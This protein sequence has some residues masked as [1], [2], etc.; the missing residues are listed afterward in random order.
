MKRRLLLATL[1]CAA[2]LNAADPPAKRGGGLFGFGAPK[3]E[4]ISAGLFPERGY[5]AETSNTIV[6]SSANAPTSGSG[7][8]EIFRSGQPQPVDAVS[9]VIQNGRKVERPIEAAAPVAATAA[10][11]AQAVAP[12]ASSGV[13]LASDEGRKR[14][15]L[16]AF[17]RRGD[18]ADENEVV[19]PVPTEGGFA[20][21]RATP[22]AAPA[23]SA[24]PAPAPAPVVAAPALA[25]P[26]I[27]AA[28]ATP[29]V[30]V[31]ETAE[32]PDFAGVEKEKGDKFGWI[33]FMGR[34]KQDGAP[35]MEAAAPAVVATAEPLVAAP[36][37][38]GAAPAPAKPAVAAAKPAAAST[39][40]TTAT[41]ATAATTAPT[42]TF[43]V[44]RD[45]SKK[46]EKKEVKP[47]S[48]GGGLLSPIANI[49]VPRKEIDL[50]SAETII[51]DGEIVAGSETNFNT[52]PEPSSTV[53]RQA[54]QVV[55]GVK[56]YTSWG[57]V[58]A[59]SS[60]AADKIIGSMR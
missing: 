35:V 57:D 18:S 48:S 36:A 58:N 34:K 47:G 15:G 22:S 10:P 37:P 7:G 20:P 24:A 27:P 9:Y 5:A 50:T 44:P 21:P 14:G 30:P 54:P 17:G 29:A 55:N 23:S 2:S 4:Q 45:E 26:A 52:V 38:T 41:T 6:T 46:A 28:P 12:A 43:E 51:Q 1:L 13:E 60:S 40:A 32:T 53:Q 25:P 8:S 59:R 56:T 31:T 11:V 39:T 3:S 49:R 33:P 16:F 42:T 19:T